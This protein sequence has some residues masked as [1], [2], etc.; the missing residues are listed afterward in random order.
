[1][2]LINGQ[3][4]SWQAYEFVLRSCFMSHW[5]LILIIWGQH[6]EIMIAI[7]CAVPWENLLIPSQ[8]LI[9]LTRSI[10]GVKWAMPLI[11]RGDS[12]EK[13]SNKALTCLVLGRS[14][15]LFSNHRWV[16]VAGR[17]GWDWSLFWAFLG[18]SEA[19]I[20]RQPRFELRAILG[21]SYLSL[22]HELPPFPTFHIVDFQVSTSECSMMD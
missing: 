13:G 19:L 4:Q 7:A 1:M 15:S 22:R 20:L 14:Q 3:L 9:I 10:G 5:L 11:M 6:Y 2:K 17:G 12:S 21:K 16:W 8:G 18:R